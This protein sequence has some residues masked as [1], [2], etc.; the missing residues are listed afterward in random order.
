MQR[1]ED[2]DVKN[3][4]QEEQETGYENAL[5]PTSLD[6]FTG[7]DKLKDNL[8]VFIQAASKRG[9]PLDHVLF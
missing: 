8:R 9:E 3:P 4:E 7:Q 2:G 5:R 6:D 1:M